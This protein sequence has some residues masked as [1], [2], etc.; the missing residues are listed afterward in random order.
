MKEQREGMLSELRRGGRAARAA[1]PRQQ[2]LDSGDNDLTD[3]ELGLIVK[4]SNPVFCARAPSH[5]EVRDDSNKRKKKER[6]KEGRKTV[7]SQQRE[8][9]RTEKPKRGTLRFLANELV[10]KLRAKFEHY[11]LTSQA[12]YDLCT[13]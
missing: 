12:S 9:K 2:V 10:L 11:L 13:Y 5:N 7:S 6:K 4:V 8:C 1:E 3:L